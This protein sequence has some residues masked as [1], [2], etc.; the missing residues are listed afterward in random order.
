MIR[1]PALLAL[2]LAGTLV[3]ADYAAPD[4]A[5]ALEGVKEQLGAALKG[6]K[7]P[8]AFVTLFGS[9]QNV[10]LISC[11]DKKLTVRI[12][13]QNF[14]LVWDKIESTE[15]VGMAQSC[16]ETSGPGTL[17]LADYCIA[18]Q[19]YV[20]AK[21]ALAASYKTP[22]PN[23]QAIEERTNYMKAAETPVS[24]SAVAASATKTVTVSS[25]PYAP[26]AKIAYEPSETGKL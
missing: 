8:E 15:L 25:G 20:R 7:K 16:L 13:D 11:D 17:A 23:R 3:A 21:Q 2:F 18:T 10:E 24:A 14:D 5:K 1:Y 19:Q 6:E 26:P 4:K 22:N 9:L 12:K